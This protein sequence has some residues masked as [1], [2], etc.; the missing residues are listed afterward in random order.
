MQKEKR[1]F[2]MELCGGNGKGTIDADVFT[3]PDPITSHFDIAGKRPGS[4]PI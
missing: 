2:Y 1:I 4:F 3:V